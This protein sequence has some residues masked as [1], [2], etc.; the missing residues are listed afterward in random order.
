MLNRC[1]H[2]LDI[3]EPTEWQRRFDLAG[4]ARDKSILARKASEAGELLEELR[5]GWQ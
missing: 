3:P 5:T 1:G 4:P 2:G